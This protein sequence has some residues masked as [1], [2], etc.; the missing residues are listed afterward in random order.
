MN[1]QTV[2]AAKR[3]SPLPPSLERAKLAAKIAV[4]LRA[5]EPCLLDLRKVTEHFD[6]FLIATGTSRRQLHAI[7]EEIDRVF[8]K[9]LGDQRLSIA[10]YDESRWIVLDY[11]DIVVHLF[12]QETREFYALEELWGRGERVEV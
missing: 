5:T 6:F 11:G 4:E 1:R 12:D 8:E 3:T 10:G 2:I 9:E 7:S